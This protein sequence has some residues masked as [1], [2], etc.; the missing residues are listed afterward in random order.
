MVKKVAKN[1]RDFC[2][3]HVIDNFDMFGKPVPAFNIKG[4]T[5]VTSR[6]GG[7]ASLLIIILSL[8]MAAVKFSHLIGKHNPSLAAYEIEHE[9]PPVVNL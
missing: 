9:E 2:T 7:C 5:S 1:R 4:K 8:S 6:M 3:Y